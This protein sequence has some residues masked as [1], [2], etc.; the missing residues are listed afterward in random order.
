MITNRTLGPLLLCLVG[1]AG[2]AIGAAS[3]TSGPTPEGAQTLMVTSSLGATSAVLFVLDGDSR[4]LAAYEAIPGA[5]G[6]LRLL[7]AR[8]IE[9]DLLLARYRDL[10]EMSPDTLREHYEA[11][12]TAPAGGAVQQPASGDSDR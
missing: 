4:R 10:S 12:G 5:N 9:H 8:R 1:I 2:L 6:G 3:S 7:G 11:E